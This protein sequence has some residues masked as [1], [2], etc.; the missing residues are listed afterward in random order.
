VKHRI[1]VK[2]SW[3]AVAL[4][5]YIVPGYLLS[6][7]GIMGWP[8]QRWEPI[9]WALTLIVWVRIAR[10]HWRRADNWQQVSMFYKERADLY[11]KTVYVIPSDNKDVINGEE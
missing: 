5:S 4:F 3:L 6:V 8:V 1:Y 11:L 2:W 7:N 10:L 9:V